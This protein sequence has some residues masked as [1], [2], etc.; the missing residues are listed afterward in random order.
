MVL[1]GITKT[2][3]GEKQENKNMLVQCSKSTAQATKYGLPQKGRRKI[4]TFCGPFD[5]ARL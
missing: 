2:I 3:I 1:L 5:T 4:N